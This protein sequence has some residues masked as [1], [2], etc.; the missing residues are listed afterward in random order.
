MFV[1]LT[2]A[3]HLF[4]AMYIVVYVFLLILTEVKFRIV[5]CRCKAYSSSGRAK[6]EGERSWGVLC[7]RSRLEAPEAASAFI[8]GREAW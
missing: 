8:M 7:T 5:A 2:F 4:D 1:K 6:L 3:K